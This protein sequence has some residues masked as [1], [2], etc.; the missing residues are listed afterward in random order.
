MT[1][2]SITTDYVT[3]TGSP[4]PYLHR[5]SEAG[6]S[7]IHW[8]HEWNTDFLYPETE[9]ER[10]GRLL[11]ELRL[12]LLDLH[13]STG[14]RSN[15]GSADEPVRAAGV[16]L[17][18]NR[19]DMTARLG[20]DVVIMHIPKGPELAP[21]FKSLD[22]LEP[23][24]RSRG[25]RLAVENGHNHDGMEAVFSRYPRDYVG[26]CWDSG[27]GN[28]E[29]GSLDWL[30]RAKDRLISIHL[31]DN[32]GATDQHKICFSGTGRAS[33]RSSPAPLMPSASAWR[34]PCGTPG[35]PTNAR[36]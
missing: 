9:I 3:G 29:P 33:S 35:S 30:D 7:H 27:H 14:P 26:L 8:C 4:D 17:V 23:F 31:H 13:G 19:V 10:I 2:L 28:L 11:A 20:S 18:R 36:S 15:W 21:L 5:I 1:M 34:F 16:E 25:V 22:E 32:D 6:F 12:Q 24:V